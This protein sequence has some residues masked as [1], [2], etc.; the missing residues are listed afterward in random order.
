MDKYY[1]MKIAYLQFLVVGN[2]GWQH[3]SYERLLKSDLVSVHLYR[4]ELNADQP[5]TTV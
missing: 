3:I 2:D 4:S 5:C 1:Y